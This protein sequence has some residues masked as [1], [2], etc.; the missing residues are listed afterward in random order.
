MK[1]IEDKLEKL[2]IYFA[3]K[4]ESEKWLLIGGVAGVIAYLGYSL[5]LPYT[6]ELFN[7]SERD[8]KRIQTKISENN[9]YLSSIT[10]GGD[11]EYYIK[12]YNKEIMSKKN[13]IV[14][15]NDKIKFIDANLEK[16][17]DMLFNQKSWSIFLNSITAKAAVHNVDL[18]YISNHYADNNGSF[19][20]VLEIGL[21]VRGTYKEITTFMNELEQNTLVT[22]IFEA[23]LALD[24]NSSDILADINISVWGINH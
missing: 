6:E 19:G 3:P 15:I 9:T 24:G 10:I 4:K 13:K 7:Q 18:E 5:L 20:H 14:N 17:S 1:L 8:K 16:L 12:T 22:D 23:K 2:D 21:G 11:R